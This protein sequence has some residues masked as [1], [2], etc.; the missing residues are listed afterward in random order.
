MRGIQWI[1]QFKTS[2]FRV[3]NLVEIIVRNRHTCGRRESH[4]SGVQKSREGRLHANLG[5]EAPN[6]SS[7]CRE[8]S[9]GSN[10]DVNHTAGPRTMQQKNDGVGRTLALSNDKRNRSL[11]AL[12]P[13]PADY[14]NFSS[15]SNSFRVSHAL[16]VLTSLF[17]PF[18]S[19]HNSWSSD[20]FTWVKRNFPFSSAE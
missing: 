19:A 17:F 3:W 6:S 15:Q 12:R 5:D 18:F 7:G 13:H 8:R 9:R 1:T 10:S 4:L 20:M 14:F 11:F 16:T 2:N